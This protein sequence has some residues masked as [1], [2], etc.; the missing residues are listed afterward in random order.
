MFPILH[1]AIVLTA[2]A[3]Y[4]SVVSANYAATCEDE[5]LDG[6]NLVAS[7]TADDGSQQS[8]TLNLNGCVASYDGDLNC[9]VNGGF[10]ASCNVASCVL[11]GGEYMQ[12]YCR[13]DQGNQTSSIVDLGLPYYGDVFWGAVFPGAQNLPYVL[14]IDSKLHLR[15]CKSQH[16]P[17]RAHYG[18]GKI[19]SPQVYHC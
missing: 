12:C 16:I 19:V 6:Q 3:L 14:Q 8:S 11:T 18:D 1:S 15:Q 4:L 9:P 7:C 2:V 10:A 17:V 13:N 5:S